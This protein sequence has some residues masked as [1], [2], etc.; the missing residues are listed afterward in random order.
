MLLISK[1]DNGTE[2]L[3]TPGLEED[4]YGAWME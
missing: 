3:R 1:E 2:S 4:D